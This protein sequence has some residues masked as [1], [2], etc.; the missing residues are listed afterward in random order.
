MLPKELQ[1]RVLDR[2][3]I[4]WTKSSQI[5]VA[6]YINIR[7]E[8]KHISRSRKDAAA[9]Q[10]MEGV[11]FTNRV[12]GGTRTNWEESKRSWWQDGATPEVDE[13]LG[14]MGHE[15]E[16]EVDQEIDMIGK[17]KGKGDSRMCYNCGGIGHIARNC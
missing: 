6:T 13:Y 7:D 3:A 9:P 8:I 11:I 14:G 17:G 2:C 15:K 5:D 4:S 16:N 12:S 10:P 1:D